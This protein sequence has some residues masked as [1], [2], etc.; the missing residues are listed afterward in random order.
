V[1]K[2]REEAEDFFLDSLAAWRKEMKMPKMILM[3]HSLGGYLAA[4]YALRYPEDV[5][6]LILVCPAGMVCFYSLVG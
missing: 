4:T 2:N 5:E 3:G 6:H 1:A